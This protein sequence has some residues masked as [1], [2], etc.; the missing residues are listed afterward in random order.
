M[1]AIDFKTIE[2]NMLAEEN[3]GR[4][5]HDHFKA[6]SVPQLKSITQDETYPFV[7][8]ALS[9]TGDLNIGSIIRSS[10]LHGAAKVFVVGRRKFDSRG[11]VGAMNYIDVEKVDG[12]EEGTI[13]FDVDVFRRVIVDN[14]LIPVFVEQGGTNL[15]EFEWPMPEVNKRIA[16]ILGNETNG[17]PDSILALQDE[18]NGY[19]VS[20]PQRGVIR[21]FNVSNAMNIVTWDM[22]SKLGW[23]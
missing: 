9:L 8:V 1:T 15:A 10:T 21:S 14:D 4:N 19:R 6:L 18:L 3:A 22:R 17:I 23:Y 11:T 5:V 7:A 2:H 12:F 20:I 16:L 13:D